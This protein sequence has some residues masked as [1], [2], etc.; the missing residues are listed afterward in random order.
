[1][2]RSSSTGRR[3]LAA[4]GRAPELHAHSATPRE[5]GLNTTFARFVIRCTPLMSV[6]PLVSVL[7][8]V[9]APVALE[10]VAPVQASPIWETDTNGSAYHRVIVC[11]PDGSYGRRDIV[12]RVPAPTRKGIGPDYSERVLAKD[13]AECSDFRRR[14]W[15]G[16]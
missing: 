12:V 13:G 5:T 14:V 1:M 2:P 6:R 7:Q 4:S 11:G 8:V 9:A 16:S 3:S 15:S 10:C